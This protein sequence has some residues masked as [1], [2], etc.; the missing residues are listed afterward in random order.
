MIADLA[1]G[2]DLSPR[3]VGDMHASDPSRSEVARFLEAC[4]AVG[5]NSDLS[6]AALILEGIKK[7]GYD[8]N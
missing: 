1:T 6:W 3:D 7:E 5:L 8:K 4:K 2:A